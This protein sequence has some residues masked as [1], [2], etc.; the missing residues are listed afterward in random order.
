MKHILSYILALGLLTA[1]PVTTVSAQDYTPVPVTVS[2][3]KVRVDGKLYYS[4]IVLERQTVYSICK[5]YNVTEEQ[6]Y[7]INPTVRTEGLKKNAVILIPCPEKE[8]VQA[9]DTEQAPKKRAERKT[10]K[11]QTV[12]TVKWYEDLDTIAEKYGVSVEAIMKANGLTGRK[13]TKRQKLIIP[14]STAPSG[15]AMPEDSVPD[16]AASPENGRPSDNG[17]LPASVPAA[18]RKVSAVLMLPFDSNGEKPR[19]GSIDFYCGTL[20]A[21]KQ[22][23]DSGTDIDLSVYDVAGGVLPI[24]VDRLSASDVV[25]GPVSA[26][27]LSALLAKC[28]S[29]TCVISPLDHRAEYLSGQYSNFVQVPTSTLTQYEDL[30]EWIREER[31]SGEEKVIVVYE[32]GARNIEELGAMNSILEKDGIPFST[33]SYS[34]LEGRDIQEPLMGMMNAEAP[35]RVVVMSESEAFVNDVVRNLNLLIHAEYDIILYAPSKIRSFETIEVDNL[36]NTHLHTSLAYYVDYEDAAVKD[37]IKRYRALYNTEPT[38]YA[39]QGYDIA[40]Y[41]LKMC[42]ASGESPERWEN[43]TV[44]RQT[45]LQSDFRFERNGTGGYVNTGVRRI[46]YGPGYSITETSHLQQQPQSVP[47]R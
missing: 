21:V 46:I 7:A 13:L 15:D 28:P 43:L 45:M 44:N 38:P 10:E 34:I 37:F 17:S 4:H 39:F 9:R 6:I 11:K 22:I 33:F 31:K 40:C 24:T 36:H 29:E 19:N 47:S 27:D 42:A 18:G 32:K 8:A 30:A 14:D 35:N 2:K 12:H 16:T 23:G 25:I 1:G 26:G 3:D 41:F 5:A 20:M